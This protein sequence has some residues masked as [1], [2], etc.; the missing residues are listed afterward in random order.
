MCQRPFGSSGTLSALGPSPVPGMPEQTGGGGGLPDPAREKNRDEGSRF[1]PRTVP[2]PLPRRRGLPRL[3]PGAYRRDNPGPQHP[4]PPPLLRF[5]PGSPPRR[6]VVCCPSPAGSPRC[7]RSFA[8]P[9]IWYLRD[10]GVGPKRFT[11]GLICQCRKYQRRQGNISIGTLGERRKMYYGKA[12]P[13]RCHMW[14]R[15]NGV[16]PVRNPV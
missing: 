11:D 12:T 1:N 6:A 14:G 9:R 16:A 4:P 8:S 3:P 13:K 5:T 10:G 2:Q 15:N 7:S